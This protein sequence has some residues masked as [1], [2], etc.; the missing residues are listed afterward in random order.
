MIINAWTPRPL[1]DDTKFEKM[2]SFDNSEVWGPISGRPG[3][4][5][6]IDGEKYLNV[7]THNYLG[8]MDSPELDE[9]AEVC[10]R[11]YGVGSC[12]PRGFYGTVGKLKKSENI[13]LNYKLNQEMNPTVISLCRFQMY[14]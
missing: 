5:L 4:F 7:A 2:D 11:R 12:G 1:V 3:K 13:E 6:E 14:T 8:L 9:A 10:I